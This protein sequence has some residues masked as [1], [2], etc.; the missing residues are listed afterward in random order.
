MSQVSH[1]FG[2][3]WIN[4]ASP[5]ANLATE[6][7]PSGSL[8]RP[9]RLPSAD[10]SASAEKQDIDSIV[11]TPSGVSRNGHGFN[12]GRFRVTTEAKLPPL[13]RFG[14]SMVW[15]WISV[16]RAGRQPAASQ[17]PRI[18]FVFQRADKELKAPPPLRGSAMAARPTRPQIFAVN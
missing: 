16:F 18:G 5:R 17:R 4:S 6:R 9:H 15:R 7:V 2:I 3:T 13:A 12:D 11:I 8:I 14:C 1:I 10:R